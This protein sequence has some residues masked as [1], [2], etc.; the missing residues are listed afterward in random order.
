[1]L[2]V[3]ECRELLGEDAPDSDRDVEALR[4]ILCYLSDVAIDLAA[5]EAAEA[6]SGGKEA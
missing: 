2:T 6:R 1:M 4:D 5:K 3:A